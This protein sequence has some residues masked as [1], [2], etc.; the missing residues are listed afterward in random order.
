MAPRPNRNVARGLGVLFRA[1]TLGALSDGQLMERFRTGRGEVSELAFSVLIERHG[2]SV[3]RTCRAVLRDE[4]AAH[5]AFQATFLVLVR[6]ARRLW[7]RESLG[8][9]LREVA[10]RV[11]NGARVSSARRRR[12]ERRYS[13]R[14]HEVCDEPCA[15]DAALGALIR[16]E[17]EDLP[18][19]DRAAVRLCDLE[20]HTHE[21]AARRLGWPLGTVKTRLTRGRKRLR[22]QLVRRGLAPAAVPTGLAAATARAAVR[23]AAGGAPFPAVS[24]LT[25][26]VLSAMVMTKVKVA[27]VAA[28]AAGVLSAGALVVAQQARPGIGVDAGVPAPDE[29]EAVARE[30]AQLDREIEAAEVAQLRELLE[31]AL[32]RKIRAER[33][34]LGDSSGIRAAR[35][36]YESMRRAYL[37]AALAIRRREGRVD[38]QAPAS[39]PPA[40]T[41]SGPGAAAAIGSID[42]DAV[43]KGYEKAEAIRKQI[44]AEAGQRKGELG[45]I[46]S[47]AQR[48]AKELESLQPGSADFKSHDAKLIQLRAQLDVAREQAQ[49]EYA[50]RETQALSALYREIQDAIAEVARVKGLVY[51]VKVSRDPPSGSD[52]NALLSA[53]NRSVVYA[54]PRT[55]ITEEVLRALNGRAD[56]PSET[57]SRP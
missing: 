57:P 49:R 23:L 5:D 50:E 18:A 34:K 51:V 32:R 31:A 36:D 8:P 53:M 22:Q 38:P 20:G 35:D 2:P 39:D 10:Y 13:E 29:Q 46:M 9:W 56:V 52:A 7:V 33:E 17:V 55:D 12:H 41:D 27:V 16:A 1:G 21:A 26:G 48:V 4:H 15:R 6:K 54:D 30:L 24:S 3:L 14:V 44:E 43:F 40:R 25:K 11:A 45:K 28:L 42:M 19:G 37:S 47:E